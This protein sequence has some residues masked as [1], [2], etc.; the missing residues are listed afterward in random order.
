LK[1]TIVTSKRRGAWFSLDRR[2][3]SI[4]YLSLKLN[5][6]FESLELLRALASIMK[7]L[8]RYG[9]TVSAWF[10]RGTKLA[11]AFSEFAVGCG[12]KSAASWR[13]D[14]SYVVYLGRVLSNSKG[15]MFSN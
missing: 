10:Q 9:D 12:N 1:K 4:L 8:E 2:E 11:W 6:K 15:G 7:K 13:N 5:V 3:K 14:R